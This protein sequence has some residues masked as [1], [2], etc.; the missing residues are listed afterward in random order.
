M[1]L[2]KPKSNQENTVFL[3][4]SQLF[5]SGSVRLFRGHTESFVILNLDNTSVDFAMTVGT[6]KDTFIRFRFEFFP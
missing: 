4:T 1:F 6:D 5:R 2:P 3:L